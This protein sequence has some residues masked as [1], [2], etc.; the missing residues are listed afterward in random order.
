MSMVELRC[1]DIF[2]GP[3]DLI[4]LPC[5]TGGTV[6]E[7]V[8]G[9]LVEYNIPY[10]ELGMKLGD[11]N[12]ELFKGGKCI[13]PHIAFAASVI[14][15]CTSSLRAIHQIGMLLGRETQRNRTIRRIAAPLLGAG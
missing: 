4:V 14:I 5:S 13:A 12:V 10:P 2:D 11:L 7:F 3:S 15:P 1:G 8:R 9:K 6:T